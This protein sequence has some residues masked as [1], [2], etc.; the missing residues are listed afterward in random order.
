MMSSAAKRIAT[1]YRRLYCTT[2]PL[3]KSIFQRPDLSSRSRHLCG[4]SESKRRID[5]RS[6]TVTVPTDGMRQA[7]FN[8][9]VGDDVLGEDPTVHALQDRVA[10]MCGKEAGLFVTSG[11]MGNLIA[12]ASHCGRGDEII[13]GQGQHIFKYEGGGASALLGVS[14]A[15]VP[16]NA[17]GTMQLHDVRS[18][19]RDDD[20]HYPI[21]KAV[22]LENTHN[23]GGGRVLPQAFI[24]SV[25]TWCHA[26]RLICHMDGARIF[27]AVV[28]SG[29]SLSRML[30]HV[31]SISICLSKGLGCPVGSVI[32]GSKEFI[33]R[34]LRARKMLGGGMRQAGVLAACG[35][36]ALDHNVERMAEDHARAKSLAAKIRALPGITLSDIETNI[37]YFDVDTDAIGMDSGSFVAGLQ[38][39][40]VDILGSMYATA[41]GTKNLFRARAVVHLHITDEDIDMIV[42]AMASTIASA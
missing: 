7:M 22:C 12:L 28:A 35:L 4:S 14:Y 34:S 23:T 5:V 16:N 37:V 29:T 18:A 13:L 40:G 6:D 42:S 30:E 8:A 38:S 17:D 39:R 10:H 41:D 20:P 26:H 31:D 33:A 36:Y 27:N 3:L 25:G 19:V 24:D 21:T 1:R 15:T 2:S 11:T 9:K 32:V